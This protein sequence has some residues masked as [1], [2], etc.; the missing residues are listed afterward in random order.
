MLRTALVVLFTSSSF[1]Q[2]AVPLRWLTSKTAKIRRNTHGQGELKTEWMIPLLRTHIV[3]WC[4]SLRPSV[5]P[6][7]NYWWPV[8]WPIRVKTNRVPFT[9]ISRQS[10]MGP[11]NTRLQSNSK[12]RRSYVENQKLAFSNLKW[13]G[14]ISIWF[15]CHASQ[16]FFKNKNKFRDMLSRSEW[17]WSKQAFFSRKCFKLLGNYDRRK[18]GW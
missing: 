9:A 10:L 2:S 13:L 18:R 11:F 14:E 16:K 12:V 15:H 7:L 5:Y 4:P 1:F 8:K 6:S 17:W 3:R